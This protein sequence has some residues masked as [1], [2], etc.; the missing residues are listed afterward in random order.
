MKNNCEHKNTRK[1]FYQTERNWVSTNYAFC[2][3]CNKIVEIT[4]IEVKNDKD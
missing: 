4:K 2:I 1:M 3:D